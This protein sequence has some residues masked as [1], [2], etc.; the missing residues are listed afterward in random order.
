MTF[1]ARARFVLGSSPGGSVDLSDL[2]GVTMALV[3]GAVVLVPWAG[4]QERPGPGLRVAREVTGLRDARSKTLQ[5]PDGSF[6]TK[7][8]R[9]SLHW[10]DRA[11]EVWREINTD[12]SQSP[13]QGV[14]FETAAGSNRFSVELAE[15]SAAGK[16]LVSFVSRGGRM[17]LAL[18]GAVVGKVSVRAAENAVSFKEVL[19]SVDIEYVVLPDGLKEN[20]VL[21]DASAPSSYAF[22]LTPG[23]NEKWRVEQLAKDGVWAF[24]VN[25]DPE[26]EFVLLPPVVGDSAGATVKQPASAVSAPSEWS[27]EHGKVSMSVVEQDDGSFL[28]TLEID[29]GWLSDPA[30]EFPVVL[31]PTVYSAPD[32]ADAEYDTTAGGNPIAAAT[33]RTGRNGVSPAAKYASVFT[34]DVGSVPPSAK[35][36]DARM[37]AYL[38]SCFPAA[39]G[40]TYTGD[41]ELRRLT[42]GWSMSTPWASVTKD[43]TLLD[44]VSFTTTPASTW[45]LWSSGAF[46]QVM[47]NMVNG[48]TVDRPGSDAGLISWMIGVLERGAGCDGSSFEVL[49][50]VAGACGEAGA[51]VGAGDLAGRA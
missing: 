28:A 11:D 30:R 24:H 26:P 31:D 47:Q 39:C 14:G 20:V 22:R 49:E 33:V 48:T 10:F 40:T 18:E 21:R 35:V 6:S 9:Q 25:G 12:V 15:R 13:K 5:Q 1:R 29:K 41:V 45:H 17:D 43:A 19:P 46:T 3:V 38:D 50:R 8:S 2:V 51:G 23:E 32:V 7:V 37:Y 36:L 42:S 44:K 27:P 16:G 4:A 34:F